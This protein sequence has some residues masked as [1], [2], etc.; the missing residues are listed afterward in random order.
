[1]TGISMIGMKRRWRLRR[2]SRILLGT[3]TTKLLGSG[4]EGI[5]TPSAARFIDELAAAASRKAEGWPYGRYVDGEPLTSPELVEGPGE[6]A[7]EP[8]AARRDSFS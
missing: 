6:L 3:T 5:R 7:D 8:Y 1:M 4:T 2:I